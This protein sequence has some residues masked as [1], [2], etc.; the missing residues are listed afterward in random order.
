MTAHKKRSRS[1]K[2]AGKKAKS[3]Q[4]R[5][6]EAVIAARGATIEDRAADFESD[7]LGISLEP[8]EMATE[9]ANETRENDPVAEG[10]MTVAPGDPPPPISR[11]EVLPALEAGKPVLIGP[12][13]KAS[14][15]DLDDYEGDDGGFRP[16]KNAP[17]GPE[18]L[19]GGTEMELVVVTLYD[20]TRIQPDTLRALQAAKSHGV[21]PVDQQELDS[22]TQLFIYK[23][24]KKDRLRLRCVILANKRGISPDTCTAIEA[25]ENGAVIP[26]DPVELDA[27]TPMVFH[28]PSLKKVRHR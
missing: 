24:L 17:D 8:A 1:R 9:T 11:D 5:A 14:L 27:F 6:H 19:T 23:P 20:R 12:D 7:E 21:F 18:E 26:V 15:P 3:P 10:R 2:K 25:A 22:W 4:Q 16:P 28:L 13:G